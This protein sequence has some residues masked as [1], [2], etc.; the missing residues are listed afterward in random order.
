VQVEAPIP[1]VEVEAVVVVFLLQQL[2][3]LAVLRTQL[4][5][6][7]VELLAHHQPMELMELIH[8]FLG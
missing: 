1:T 5:L 8:L 6:V 3:F 7:L 2:L 4:L